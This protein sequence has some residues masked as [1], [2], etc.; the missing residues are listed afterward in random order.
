MVEAGFLRAVA[1][2]RGTEGVVCEGRGMDAKYWGVVCEGRTL[3]G[4][5][6]RDVRRGK[7]KNKE[8]HE[9]QEDQPP[10]GSALP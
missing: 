7:T 9:R 8:E 5:E 6:S 4:G 1:W 3:E 10:Q 2:V